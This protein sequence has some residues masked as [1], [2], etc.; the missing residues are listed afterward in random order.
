MKFSQYVQLFLI[1]LVL[2]FAEMGD[3]LREGNIY[4]LFCCHVVVFHHILQSSNLANISYKLEPRNWDGILHMHHSYFWSLWS[5]FARR[6]GKTPTDYRNEQ[7]YR[8]S[9]EYTKQKT[10]EV[11]QCSRESCIQFILDMVRFNLCYMYRNGSPI[12]GFC[13]RRFSF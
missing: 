10:A 4:L 12:L 8:K 9:K 6:S 3:I 13:C 7:R 11:R 2:L 1:F 5:R